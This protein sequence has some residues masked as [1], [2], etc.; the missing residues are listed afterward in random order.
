MRN[1]LLD[2]IR[3]LAAFM[4]ILIHAPLPGMVGQTLEAVCRVA[5]P[6]FFGISG[7]Y[8]FGKSKEKLMKSAKKTAVM[9][10]WSVSI[11]FLW[12]ILWSVYTGTTAKYLAEY[13]SVRTL[14]ETVFLNTGVLLGH[15]WFLLAL[16]YCYLIY[17]LLLRKASLRVR[18]GLSV[19]LLAGFF[20][21]RELLKMKGISDPL[22]YLRNF[23]FVGIPFFLLGG[24]INQQKERLIRLPAFFWIVIACAGTAAAIAERFFVG[25][26]DLY[27]GTVVAGVALFV[28][29]QMPGIPTGNFLA[30]LGEK[31]AGDIYVFHSMIIVIL[32]AAASVIGVLHTDVFVWLR[33]AMVLIASIGV[34]CIKSLL[35]R[36]VFSK[37]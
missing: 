27:A 28:F 11:Y 20:L 31:Y 35:E 19:A 4:V 10:L 16:L 33:P 36:K 17:A 25:C 24:I 14:A 1:K 21:V 22:Y 32:N 34:A 6:L 30:N 29:T 9:L 12:G 5:V 15:L 2:Q 13:F 26:Y 23:L 18:T 3:L 7:Y 37:C 8:A